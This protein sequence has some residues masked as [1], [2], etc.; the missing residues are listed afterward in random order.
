MCGNGAKCTRKAGYYDDRCGC[1]GPDCTIEIKGAPTG[2]RVITGSASGGRADIRHG[3]T[4]VTSRCY[5]QFS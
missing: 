5:V 1:S 4:H 3:G 2:R